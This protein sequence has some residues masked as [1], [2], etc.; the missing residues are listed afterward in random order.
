MNEEAR[1]ATLTL[2]AQRAPGDTICRSEVAR[3]TTSGPAWPEAIPVVH[4][5]LDRLRGEFTVQL[6]WK[7]QPLAVRDGPYRIRRISDR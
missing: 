7:G 1:E 5:A 6:S 3:A 2:L 4:A